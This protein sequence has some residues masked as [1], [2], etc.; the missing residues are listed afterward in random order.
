MS[1]G[2]MPVNGRKDYCHIAEAATAACTARTWHK[3]MA[4][5]VTMAAEMQQQ[6]CVVAMMATIYRN[7]LISSR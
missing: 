2:V 6:H 3:T 5:A 4:T 1:G 7:K